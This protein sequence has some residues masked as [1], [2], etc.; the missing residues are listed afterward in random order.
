M[1]HPNQ[2]LYKHDFYGWTQSQVKA[3]EKACRTGDAQD[4]DF[5]N[6]LEE[7]GDLGRSEHRTLSGVVANAIRHLLALHWYPEDDACSKWYHEIE[8]FRRKILQTL[9]E[10][11]SLRTELNDPSFVE[12]VWDA[13]VEDFIDHFGGDSKPHRRKLKTQL[14][15]TPIWTKTEI[16]GFQHTLRRKQLPR[17]NR[18]PPSLPDALFDRLSELNP[19]L[20]L[21]ARYSELT[22][23][24]S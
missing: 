19:T 7:I 11:P 24:E 10:N 13:G 5:R 20:E 21:D 8:I 2:Q 1:N 17:F 3:L 18:L 22:F 6:I 9:H 12:T 14:P 4:V 16:Y 15:M 23:R